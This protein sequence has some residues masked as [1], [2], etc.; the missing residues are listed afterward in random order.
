MWVS[1][2]HFLN[3]LA[4]PTLGFLD[5]H[6]TNGTLDAASQWRFYEGNR[7]GELARSALGCG[8][9]LPPFSET[10]LSASAMAIAEGSQ[11]LFE[12]SIAGAGMFAR[13]D[14]PIPCLGGW[15][16]LEVKSGKMPE[17]GVPK[18]DY[19][20]DVAY[21]LCVAQM[22]QVRVE[23]V[24]LMLLSREYT[25]GSSESMFGKLDVT[26]AAVKRAEEMR[27]VAPSLVHAICGEDQPTPNLRMTCKDCAN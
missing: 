21:T 10:A 15:E 4:C 19:V 18:P 25:R 14:A 26:A 2:S 13:A 7:V 24:S 8:R 17:N 27:A 5:R 9:M 6:R 20:D 23:R 1:K 11:T 22:A 3:A 12:V 16:L